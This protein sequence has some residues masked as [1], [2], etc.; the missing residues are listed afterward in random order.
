MA[1]LG[2]GAGGAAEMLLESRDKGGDGIVAA[3]QG[4][5]GDALPLLDFGH[6]VLEAHDLQPASERLPGLPDEQ[7]G[8]GFFGHAEMAAPISHASVSYTHL[9]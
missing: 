5:G 8:E 1:A 7:A 6:C 3:V 4:D 2:D 9:V